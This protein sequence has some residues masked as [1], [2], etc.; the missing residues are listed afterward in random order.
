MTCLCSAFLVRKAVRGFVDNL[1]FNYI[2]YCCKIR[3]SIPH[4]KP[5]R[6]GEGFALETVGT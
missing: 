4:K 2:K 6:D 5:A 1:S 3:L